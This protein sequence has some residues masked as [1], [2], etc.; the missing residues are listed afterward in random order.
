MRSN[1]AEGL[2]GKKQ[3]VI[4]EVEIYKVCY[5]LID[6]SGDGKVSIVDLIECCAHFEPDCALGRELH[7]FLDQCLI[8]NVLPR[9]KFAHFE[10]NFSTY[11]KFFERPCLGAQL[12]RAFNKQFPDKLMPL[13]KVVFEK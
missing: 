9:F 2:S 4:R 10:I 1:K 5:E 8:R 12:D 6:I 11:V 3:S 13:E 7:F